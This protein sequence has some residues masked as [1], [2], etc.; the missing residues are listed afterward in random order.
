MIAWSRSSDLVAAVC[1]D[2]GLYIYDS[3]TR[4]LARRLI[5]HN[6]AVTDL[7]FDGEG[8]HV[9]SSSMD[10]TIRTWDL[11][12]GLVVD[13]LRCENAPTSV[14]IAPG[15]EFLATCHVNSLSV[16]LWVDRK[17]FG[18]LSKIGKSAADST[19]LRLVVGG[20]TKPSEDGPE[21]PLPGAFSR[22]D[23]EESESDSTEGDEDD[24]D[25]EVSYQRVFNF[26]ENTETCS[27]LEPELVT[28]SGQPT[29]QWSTLSNLDAIKQRNKP[30]QPPKK[31]AQVPFFI[32]TIAGIRPRFDVTSEG[33]QG[34]EQDETGLAMG[35]DSK[36]AGQA[37]DD[38]F[39]NSEFGALVAAE[40]FELA[41]KLMT[42]LGPSKVDVEL[43]TLEGG[44]S[45]VAAARYFAHQLASRQDF[46]LHQA[47][48]DVFLKAHGR[49]LI[50][51][52]GGRD[53]LQSL[54]GAQS[55]AWDGLRVSFEAV[56]TLAGHFSGQV[57]I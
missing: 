38:F 7:S 25:S 23:H 46:E 19:S 30:I 18:P 53:A 12:S 33:A 21:V 43:R 49:D 29:T 16:A 26:D 44:R 45:R 32:P 13:I 15:G 55:A 3:S 17:R 39:E 40:S 8:R 57:Q 54:E 28:L 10:G 31:Q 56:L 6:G 41:R 42:T 34:D 50:E 5:G 1:E 11:P 52:D 27:P 48:L 2:F 47:H 35:R 36:Q 51:D 22:F 9:V 14:T 20:L 4:K 37:G 24:D